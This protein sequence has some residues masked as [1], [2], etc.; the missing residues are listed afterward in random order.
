MKKSVLNYTVDIGL[1]VTFIL[2]FTTAIIK[3]PGFLQKIGVNQALFPMYTIS[4]I[5]D[6]SGIAMGVLVAAHLVLHWKW[7]VV[8]TRKVVTKRMIGAAVVI[9]TV[10]GVILMVNPTP[11]KFPPVIPEY[12]IP[13]TP[14]EGSTIFGEVR[15]TEVTLPNTIFIDDIGEFEF[16]PADIEPVRKDIF[17][18]GYFSVFAVLVHLD[19]EGKIGMEYHFDTAMDTHVIDSINGNPTWWYTAHYSGGWPEKN[20]YRMDYYPYKD[21]MYIRVQHVTNEVRERIHKTFKEEVERKKDKTVIPLV[22]IKG[23]KTD[24]QIENV[25]VAAHNLRNDYFQDGVITAMD[26]VLSLADQGLLSYDLYWYD[27]IGTADIVR[28]FWVNRINQDESRG[29][30]GFVYEAGS[31][32]YFGFKGNHIHIPA[33]LRVIMSPEYVEFFWICL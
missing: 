24:L 15:N 25:E 27:S 19:N 17:K 18:D 28:S 6:W 31:L 22:I 32:Q 3:F 12:T 23:I 33:D 11:T 1:V 20:V 16:D 26:V 14:P 10:L 29:R 21:N 2:S 9:F 13:F 8:M 7:L 4:V 5:H 30:C